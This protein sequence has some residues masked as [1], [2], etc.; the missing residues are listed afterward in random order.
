MAS[1]DEGCMHAWI[2]LPKIPPPCHCSLCLHMFEHQQCCRL[3]ECL[4]S[5]SGAHLCNFSFLAGQLP[6]VVVGYHWWPVGCY[7]WPVSHCW[8]PI[9]HPYPELPFAT[10]ESKH[11]AKQCILKGYLYCYPPYHQRSSKECN[12]WLSNHQPS[13]FHA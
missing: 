10:T 3:P 13:I 11:E 4:C 9:G 7:W 6:M 8:W 2:L 5:N 1:R 12:S